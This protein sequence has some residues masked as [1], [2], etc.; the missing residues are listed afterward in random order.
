[1]IHCMRLRNRLMTLIYN[2][3]KIFREKIKQTKRWIIY[4]TF[5]KMRRIILNTIAITHFANHFNIILISLGTNVNSG[6]PIYVNL[7]A[8]L[9]LWRFQ[10]IIHT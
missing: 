1:M 9:Y 2:E 8:G 4:T 6:C 5:L 7:A 3:C 10:A